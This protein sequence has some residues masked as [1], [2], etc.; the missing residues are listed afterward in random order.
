MAQ[1]FVELQIKQ[2]WYYNKA[3]RR[4]LINIAR[5]VV[6]YIHQL[7]QLEFHFSKTRN[8]RLSLLK[9]YNYYPQESKQLQLFYEKERNT[10]S[11]VIGELIITRLKEEQVNNLKK[12][13]RFYKTTEGINED[14]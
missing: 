12:L 3:F 1:S 4:L 10:L 14:Y 11:L 9:S 5:L 8:F 13:S 7:Y 6:K 2:N